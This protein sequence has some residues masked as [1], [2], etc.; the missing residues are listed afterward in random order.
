MQVTGKK[1]WLVLVLVS[2]LG[3]IMVYV[4]FLR[5][6]Y[7][8]Q[9]ILVFTQFKPIV[10]ESYVNEFIGDIGLWFGIF[11]VLTYPIGGI[12]ADKFS[13]R[14]LLVI[15]AVMMGLASFWYGVVPASTPILLIHVIYGVGTSVFIWSAYLKVVRKMGTAGEQGRMFS[16][17]EF[18]RAIMGMTIGFLGVSLLNKAVFPTG[19]MSAEILGQ[20]WQNMLFFNGA[21]FIILALLVFIFVPKNII[22]AEEKPDAVQ[23]P[24]SMKNILTV[25]KMPGT[26]LL[27]GLIFFCFSFTSAGAGYLGAYT[28]NVL[29]ISETQAST[30]SVVRNYIIAGISTLA[31]GFIAD[32]IGSKVKTLGIYLVLATLMTVIMILTKDLTMLCIVV[33][34]VFATV[35]TGMRGIY[36][37]TLSEVGIPLSL[38]GVAAGII[39]LICYLPDIYFAKLAGSWLDAYG[40]TGYDYIWLWA[41]GCGVLG[42]IIAVITFRYS[43]K[44]QKEN[45]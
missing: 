25:L 9:M 27:A 29:G 18:V 19:G 39:S 34:F 31:I 40:N 26:W 36:F 45:N 38:T 44:I 23:E 6:N 30:F 43:K 42:I 5:Y 17:S 41:V 7:Y 3:G 22:G 11:S 12:M 24:F 2:L 37:A 16:T 4:P 32:K 33:T 8:D 13:E 21:L 28:T 1:R 15:G 10:S 20:Q 35:Y 14:N